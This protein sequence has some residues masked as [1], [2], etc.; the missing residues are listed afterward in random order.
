MSKQIVTFALGSNLGNRLL[1]L[2]TALRSLQENGFDIKRKSRVWET[3]PWGKLNQPRFLNMCV[4]AETA[5]ACKNMLSIIKAIECKIG[6]KETEKW[7]GREIDIDIIFVDD[8]IFENN[9][10]SV[11]HKLVHERAFVLKP[12]AEIAPDMLH[13]QLN[14]TVKEL[15][16]ALPE[17]KMEWIMKL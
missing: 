10:L 11:P 4:I 15:L 5:I 16:E 8:K 13:P 3:A 7:G 2:D 17:E 14:K 1:Y 9:N 12:L 6:R